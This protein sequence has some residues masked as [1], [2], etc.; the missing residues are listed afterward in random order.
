MEHDQRFKTMLR[1]FFA[2]FLWL[3]FAKWAERFDLTRIEWFDKEL[4]GLPAAPLH[5]ADLVAR[6]HAK[7]A[8]AR[9]HDEV[10]PPWLILVHME[11]ESA[12]RTTA[13]KE[14]M[15]HY[16]HQLRA[17]HG[18]PVLPIVLF[19]RMHLE[20]IAEDVCVNRFWELEVNVFRYLC[21]GLAGLPA[22][23]YLQGESWLG[24]A[25]SALMDIEPERA[26]W[27]GAE[28]LKRLVRAPLST[29]E[30]YLLA[31]CV[32]RY[33]PLDDEQQQQFERLIQSD[34]YVEVR[35]MKKSIYEWEM[36]KVTA[37][38]MEKGIEKGIEKGRLLD[39]QEVLLLQ[40]EER[41]GP[42]SPAIRSHIE[43]LSWD[44]LT[45]LTRRIVK[46]KS[47]AELGLDQTAK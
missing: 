19:L 29:S 22:V 11:I 18:L 44:G 12:E 14:R 30:R 46:A 2:E 43:N 13:I 36:E 28:A 45:E 5:V 15:P 24:V 31:E 42:A 40:V 35:T 26:A 1:T 39:R 8:V 10:N 27:L 6:V 25:L 38:G 21:V 32:H 41:F 37:Q 3:F 17:Q 7:E 20:G 47:L 33:K 9:V 34:E 4:L 16:Y 23:Q